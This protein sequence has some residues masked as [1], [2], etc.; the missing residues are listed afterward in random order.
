MECDLSE[1]E[2]ESVQSFGGEK[3]EWSVISWGGRLSSCVILKGKAELLCD[4]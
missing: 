2:A 3:L 1:G 4:A